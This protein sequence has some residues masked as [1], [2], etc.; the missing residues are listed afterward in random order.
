M[1]TLEP[2]ASNR[3][4]LIDSAVT[5]CRIQID[6]EEEWLQHTSLSK[7]NTHIE[8]LWFDSA[9]MVT[10][11]SARIQW[12]DGRRLWHTLK[13]SRKFPGR[14]EFCLYCY[15]QDEKRADIIQ[16]WFN[17]FAAYF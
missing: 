1:Q 8:R 5:V 14:R 13:I 7:P 17:Y 11:C 12:L 3:N 6:Y 16:L 15:G 4:T 9:D 10:N 2:T